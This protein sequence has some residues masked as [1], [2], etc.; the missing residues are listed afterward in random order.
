MASFAAEHG[1]RG[2]QASVPVAFGLSCPEARGIFLGQGWNL[3][4]VHGQVDSYPLT[5]REV[6]PYTLDK[7][8]RSPQSQGRVCGLRVSRR[9][10]RTRRVFGAPRLDASD[11]VVSQEAAAGMVRAK[12]RGLGAWG[13]GSGVWGLGRQV[14]GRSGLRGEGC[15]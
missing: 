10:A 13:L 2:A 12:E 9:R 3:C 1:L 7:H 8:P 11:H 4:P 6:P 5:T 15:G 14:G